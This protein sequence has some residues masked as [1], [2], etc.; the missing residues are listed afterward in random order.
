MPRIRSCAA[1]ICVIC[2]STL[3]GCASNRATERLV[4]QS[5]PSAS[6]SDSVAPARLASFR[7][8]SARTADLANPVD[9]MALP[10]E[11]PEAIAIEELDASPMETHGAEEPLNVNLP[12]VLSMVGGTHPTVAFA[13]WR[14]QES[15]AQLDQAR[16]LWLPTIRGGF[17]FHRHDG[18][19]QASDGRIVDVH[20]NSF[21][22]GL[23]NGATGAGTTPV[24]GISAQFR[25]ADAIFEP[26]V[27]KRVS[28]ARKYGSIA[29]M[30]EQ[31]MLV[32]TAYT[33]LVDAHQDYQI[34][35]ESKNLAEELTKLTLDFAA[36]GEGLQSDS[37]RMQTE[38]SLVE[39]RMLMAQ[40]TIDLAAARLAEATSVNAGQQ[41]Y[42]MDVAVI[43]LQLVSQQGDKATMIATGL[44]N[45][46]ELKE[47]QALV[48]A[49]CQRL[50]QE[51]YAPFLPSVLLGF[52]SGGFGGGL[53]S[54]LD[55]IDGRY[56]FDAA[57]SWEVRNL[58]FGERAA[59]DLAN[60]RIQQAKYEK[61]RAM[62][63]VARQVSESHAQV[64]FRRQQIDVTQQ[65]IQS[66]EQSH[67]RNVGRIRD[68]Q[69]IPLEALQ[70]LQA[71]ETARR[72]Y[73]EAVTGYN[74]AQ[75][76]L[77]W[78]LGWPITTSATTGF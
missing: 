39:N 72:A 75:I 35:R 3:S 38:M 52:S 62:D 5:S 53:G 73:R 65:A 23:G 68:G 25:L 26:A 9:E 42:P 56:D 76:R 17:S 60:S 16:V 31:L 77:Q 27:A 7:L 40:E 14:I 28:T 44:S 22:Y 66:A 12:T 63:Q 15:Y 61:L 64:V 33:E 8:A 13:Q 43:P 37:D 54:D 36:A 11:L 6:P 71:L 78:A 69:G 55:D 29:T 59:R 46:P 32:S 70:S 24:P 30:N 18:N 21:Q 10:P 57:M 34:L 67:R 50:K 4:D 58:G 48:T 19:Y 74:L 45:R 49:A 20:R 47:S 2:I 51:R 41:L 1:T